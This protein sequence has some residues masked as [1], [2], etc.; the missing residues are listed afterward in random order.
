MA[1]VWLPP[2]AEGQITHPAALPIGGGGEYN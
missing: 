2:S 1:S